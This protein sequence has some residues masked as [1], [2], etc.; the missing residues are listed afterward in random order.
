MTRCRF[1]REIAK[2][3]GERTRGVVV[4]LP[5]PSEGELDAEA[6]FGDRWRAAAACSGAAAPGDSER[7]P[8]LALRATGYT[9]GEGE[10][11]TW[12]SL[13]TSVAQIVHHCIKVGHVGK[14]GI[15]QFVSRYRENGRCPT[16]L[17]H[18]KG[19]PMVTQLFIAETGQIRIVC[20]VCIGVVHRRITMNTRAADRCVSPLQSAPLLIVS[21]RVCARETKIFEAL[22]QP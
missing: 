10:S 8:V 12:A 1:V 11:E 22:V 3:R 20:P 18:A 5:P 2:A 17:I 4:N 13:E 19:L 16:A 6:Q 15:E 7:S 9:S 21:Y 14:I